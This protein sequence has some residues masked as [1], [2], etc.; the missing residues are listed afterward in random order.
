MAM[1]LLA[2]AGW[3]KLWWRV[4]APILR[5]LGDAGFPHRCAAC[6]KL[7][8]AGPPAVEAPDPVA[9]KIMRP[10]VCPGCLEG[11][12]PMEH[13]L[14]TC[15]G[16][17][18]KG[19]TGEDHPCGRC[20]ESPPAFRLARAAVVYDRSMVAVIQRFKYK[21][22]AHLAKPLGALLG[23]AFRCYWAGAG[24]DLVL[25]VPL[26][27]RRLKTRGFNQSLLLIRELRRHGGVAGSAVETDIL[28]R[29]R[30]TSTQAGLRRSERREN[31]SGAFDVRHPERIKG[32]RV[33]LVDDVITTG[34]TADAC[35]RVLLENDATRVDVLAVAR[36]L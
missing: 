9:V 12:M 16:V 8:A 27:R 29:R 19:R 17:M 10:Y 18:F 24:I 35:A 6:G 32:K 31:V 2:A 28:V 11:L 26:H 33:L 4:G 34:A 25:P 5:A 1:D 21:G 20:I 30:A 7:L 22:K 23:A 14:C 15:C 3:K 36:V 13:P